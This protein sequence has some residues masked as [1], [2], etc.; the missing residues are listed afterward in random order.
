MGTRGRFSGGTIRRSGLAVVVGLSICLHGNYAQ[1]LET[2]IGLMLK[3]AYLE[4]DQKGAYSLK[5]IIV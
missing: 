2:E 1:A 3:H 5:L 4:S